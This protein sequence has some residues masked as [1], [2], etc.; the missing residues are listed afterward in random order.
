M[1]EEGVLCLHAEGSA[2]FSTTATAHFHSLPLEILFI[3][4]SIY[5]TFFI[6]ERTK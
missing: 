6:L 5:P 3:F 1:M 4:H 2:S